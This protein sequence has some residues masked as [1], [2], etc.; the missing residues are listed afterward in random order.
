[1]RRFGFAVLG[2]SVVACLI[3]E[4]ALAQKVPLFRIKPTEPVSSRPRIEDPLSTR[5]PSSARESSGSLA[6]REVIELSDPSSESSKRAN[7]D[8]QQN[9][10]PMWLAEAT[11]LRSY[12]ALQGLRPDFE[13]RLSSPAFYLLAAGL[14]ELAKSDHKTIDDFAELAPDR[15]RAIIDRALRSMEQP[16]QRTMSDE[17]EAFLR[18]K[19]NPKL[20]LPIRS[21]T[22]DSDIDIDKALSLD[23]GELLA[24]MDSNY[25]RKKQG[26]LLR[27]LI[28]EEIRSVTIVDVAPSQVQRPSNKAPRVPRPQV[29][30]ILAI[31]PQDKGAA[32][33]RVKIANGSDATVRDIDLPTWEFFNLERSLTRR[34]LNA[35]IADID[36]RASLLFSTAAAGYSTS[37][38][39]PDRVTARTF[40]DSPRF[41]DDHLRNLATVASSELHAKTTAFFNFVGP[42]SQASASQ[43]RRWSELRIKYQKAAEDAGLT[44]KSSRQE[45]FDILNEGRLDTLIVV[46]HGDNQA[47][48]L[49]NGEKMTLQGILDLP[50]L[51]LDRRPVIILVSCETGSVSGAGI[52]S[53]A[54][55][56]LYK[57]R[58]SAVVAPTR[59]IPAETE[60][61]E[62]VKG[63][64]LANG[65]PK[66]LR[67]FAAGLRGPWQLYVEFDLLP[68]SRTSVKVVESVFQ[69]NDGHEEEQIHRRAD[70]RVCTIA[71]NGPA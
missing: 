16:P 21:A 34:R 59:R 70:H 24:K 2:V 4:I 69:E 3:G 1:V 17:Y 51:R 39:F 15:R 41:M 12:G 38:L 53:I 8:W 6:S 49:P 56:L 13:R 23:V 11:G 18:A 10:E 26:T 14:F 29:P 36:P 35:A 60:S 33:Y 9:F 31:E 19:Q 32:H 62:F 61:L 65:R 57:G 66:R 67:E 30:P 43:T 27:D 28:W 54:Q 55:A 68:S 50:P 20:Q 37:E 71:P 64:F 5:V 48:Y 52:Q 44:I 46:A 7:K 25:W 58:A 45:L 63:L 22:A 42:T 47:I 40:D